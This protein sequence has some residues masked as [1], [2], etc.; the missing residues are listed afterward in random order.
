MDAARIWRQLSAMAEMQD[1][2]NLLVHPRWRHQGHDYYRA[3]WVEC[4]E[5]LDH[6]GWKWWK[7]QQADLE[8]VKLEII[9]IWHFGL[10]EL[11]RANQMDERL[12]ARLANIL[13]SAEAVDFRASVEDLALESLATKQFDLE[14]FVTVM[15]AL[16]MT[17]DELYRGY[18]AKNVLNAFRQQHGYQ[19]GSYRKLWHDGREDNEHLVEIVAS[20]DADADSF[21][22]DLKAAIAARY[23]L[24]SPASRS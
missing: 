4:A 11:L 6:F 8:Q 16:P 21:V 15:R 19:D 17:F 20:L 7:Q 24:A 9:D 14:A 3:V 22:A 10:S 12:V 18:V 1:D 2:H 5:L 23:A 13:A